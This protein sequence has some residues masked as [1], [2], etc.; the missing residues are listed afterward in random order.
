MKNRDRHFN[1]SLLIYEYKQM[2]SIS[3]HENLDFLIGWRLSYL[4]EE[5]CS[6]YQGYMLKIYK[7][8]IK[9]IEYLFNRWVDIKI[10][11]D[12]AAKLVSK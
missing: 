4:L 6:F 11:D 7:F 8:C 3:I 12:V 10:S 1:E 2:I 9:F 5:Q